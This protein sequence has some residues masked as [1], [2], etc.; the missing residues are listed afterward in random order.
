[1]VKTMTLNLS[2]LEMAA[3]DE[4]AE[5]KGMNKTALM[6]QALRLYQTIDVRLSRGEKIFFENNEKQK[7][8]L[9]LL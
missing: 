5:R 4:L 7:S 8:E 2:E 1:M 9:V 6:K 3:I